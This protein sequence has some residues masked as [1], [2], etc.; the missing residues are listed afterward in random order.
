MKIVELSYRREKCLFYQQIC[1]SSVPKLTNEFFQLLLHKNYTIPAMFAKPI[2]IYVSI[3]LSI[4][5]Y[6][7]Q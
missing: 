1:F 7:I 2:A 3:Y 5:Y 4:R 6:S